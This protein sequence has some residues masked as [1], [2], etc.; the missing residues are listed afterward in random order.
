MTPRDAAAIIAIDFSLR[1]P[2]VLMGRRSQKAVFMPGVF[3]FPGGRVEPADY[4][5]ALA[6]DFGPETYEKLTQGHGRRSSPAKAR[7]LGVAALRE[8]REEAGIVAARALG[9]RGPALDRLVY[10]ARA[11][12]PPGQKRIFDT[13]FFVL[14]ARHISD[15]R[16]GDGEL[17]DIVWLRFEDARAAPLHVITR[18]ILDHVETRLKYDGLS[19]LQQGIP[20]Y[21]KRGARFIRACA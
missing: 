7:A 18:T 17:S 6:S 9:G 21:F 2:R 1:H 16:E 3:V 4:R 15:M 13:R 11:I 12:T 14:D 5:V 20:C 8:A 19:G 10:A